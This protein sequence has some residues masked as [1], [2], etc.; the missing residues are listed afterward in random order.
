MFG[1]KKKP[2]YKYSGHELFAHDKGRDTNALLLG[3]HSFPSGHFAK[4]VGDAVIHKVGLVVGW[5]EFGRFARVGA[6]AVA[7]A[8]LAIPHL[9]ASFN[10]D[11]VFDHGSREFGN[12]FFVG[13]GRSG[14]FR[15]NSG[16][17]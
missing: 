1:A 13:G 7:M 9:F 4:T 2:R 3:K 11:R 5:F 15:P 10:I 16:A 17:C 6:V 12:R 14:F 8:A